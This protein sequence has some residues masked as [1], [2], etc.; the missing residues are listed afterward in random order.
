MEE[1]N[2]QN[3]NRLRRAVKFL[4]TARADLE[5][6]YRRED[7]AVG[8]VEGAIICA[9]GLIELAL[10]DEGGQPAPKITLVRAEQTCFGCPSQWDAWDAEGSQYYLRFRHGHGTVHVRG[11]MTEF[12]MEWLDRGEE[13]ASFST[14]D[15]YDGIINLP[16]F[17]E[18]AGITLGPMLAAW[19]Q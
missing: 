13:I 11:R 3:M 16:E 14:D 18:R 6:V 2:E 9:R 15:P 4:E 1:M 8:Q 5:P 7:F 19:S 10:I 17:A 12:G